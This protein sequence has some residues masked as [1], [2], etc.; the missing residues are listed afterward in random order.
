M[1]KVEGRV[2]SLPLGTV[3]LRMRYGLFGYNVVHEDVAL[4]PTVTDQH[5]AKMK[6]KHELEHL[7][8]KLPGFRLIIAMR[9][10]SGARKSSS[11]R[12]PL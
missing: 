11:C 2:P 6:L 4:V 1:P 8:D 5:A 9:F 7:G 10:G 3:V 12:R